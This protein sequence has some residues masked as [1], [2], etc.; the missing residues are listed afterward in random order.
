MSPMPVQKPHRSKQDYRT[1][2]EFI[3]AV[4]ARY[5]IT[6]FDCDL[7]ADDDNALAPLYFTK[8]DSAFDAP[9]WKCGD[10]W[11]WMNPEFSDI[12]PWVHR[13]FSECERN[14]ARTLV[15]VP[16]S[17]GANWF[18]DYVHGKAWVFFLNGR[19]KFVGCEDYYPKDCI[20]IEYSPEALGRIREQHYSGYEVWSWGAKK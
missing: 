4:K 10:G 3:A 13:A 12:G 7:A 15:L 5:G 20:L 1:P 6:E 14:Q 9:T 17:I 8:Q 11:N 2:P 18:R 19:L 16:G